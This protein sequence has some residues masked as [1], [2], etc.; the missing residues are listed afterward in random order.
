[1]TQLWW[2]NGVPSLYLQFGLEIQA[3]QSASNDTQVG[4][5]TSLIHG[6]GGSL[7]CPHGLCRL[8]WR[9]GDLHYC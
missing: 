4:R 5:Y 2:V 8:W 6:E 1:M 9:E 7:G 3:L